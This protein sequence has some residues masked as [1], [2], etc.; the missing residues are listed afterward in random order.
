MHCPKIGSVSIRIDIFECNLTKFSRVMLW[1]HPQNS[2]W[3]ACSSCHPYHITDLN[4]F[5]TEPV[6]KIFLN[7]TTAYTVTN[8]NLWHYAELTCCACSLHRL[9]RQSPCLPLY[10][11]STRDEQ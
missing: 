7:A 2:L 9:S 4:I 11:T 5:L 6:L 8:S 3:M 1:K 10:C